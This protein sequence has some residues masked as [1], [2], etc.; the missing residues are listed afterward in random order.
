MKK[1]I[2]ASIML[3]ATAATATAQIG[4]IADYNRVG[5]TYDNTRY[6]DSYHDDNTSLNGLGLNY[7]HGFMLTSSTPMFL[8]AGAVL[9]FKFGTP[10]SYQDE[11]ESMRNLNIEV[12]VNFT[13]HFYVTDNITIA[14]YAGLNFKL[15]LL[16]SGRWEEAGEKS[17]WYSYFSKD[18]M[19]EDNTW[20]RFQ[21]G[22]QIG[23]SLHYSRYSLALQY[24][25][26]F[27]PAYHFSGDGETVNINTAT[28][29]LAL[30][31]SF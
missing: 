27:I 2:I 7:V 31:Y 3:A 18:D 13:Y 16:T 22:W 6:H 23:V 28:F 12:P 17:D 4:D 24:G 26:D 29:R 8:E 30:G 9:N 25:T 21:M 14:P 11:K 20:N 5:L 19:G 1:I 15:H 10:Y